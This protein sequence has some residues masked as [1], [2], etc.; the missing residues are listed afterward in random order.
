MTV[1]PCFLSAR[2]MKGRYVAIQLKTGRFLWSFDAEGRFMGHTINGGR[3]YT[4]CQD[5]QLYAL[6]MASGRKDWAVEIDSVA[7][8]NGQQEETDAGCESK[9]FQCGNS[10]RCDWMDIRIPKPARSVTIDVP[11]KLTSGSGMP[12]TGTSPV[13][14]AVLT[15]T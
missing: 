3:I 8:R 14:I 10:L 9:S 7:C 4:T 5:G 6:D 1:A 15:K 12:T 11:P 13:T 2:A